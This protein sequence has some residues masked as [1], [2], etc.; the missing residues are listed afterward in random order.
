M[1]K[2]IFSI[3]SL[4]ICAAMLSGCGAEKSNGKTEVTS[5]PETTASTENAS[6]TTSLTSEI[7]SETTVEETE[8]EEQINYQKKRV[9]T[10]PADGDSYVS[11]EYEYIDDNNY[12]E[13][14]LYSD[15]NIGSISEYKNDFLVKYTLYRDGRIVFINE[16]D[17]SELNY[18]IQ[19]SFYDDNQ[20]LSS[21]SFYDYQFNND[22]TEA[23][24]TVKGTYYN[25]ADTGEKKELEDVYIVYKYEYDE[26]GHIVHKYSYAK[27]NPEN[28]SETYYEYDTNG[29]MISETLGDIRIYKYEYEDNNL[30]HSYSIRTEDT[31]KHEYDY[32]YDYDEYGRQIGW[33]YEDENGVSKSVVEYD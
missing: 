22:R 13:T 9:I 32:Y 33:T 7:I 18:L 3:C 20:E 14:S 27:D 30:I 11:Y 1:K 19:Q 23:L 29:N 2:T 31:T 21:D 26:A 17:E 24:A 5:N 6:E 8:A 10:C 15:G 25:Y 16:N 12:K 28:I 4:I